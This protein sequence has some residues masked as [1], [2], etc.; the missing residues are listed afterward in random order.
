MFPCGNL[1]ASICSQTVDCITVLLLIWF[2]WGTIQARDDL[3][4]LTWAWIFW[5]L[6]FIPSPFFQSLVV[7]EA[8]SVFL[9]LFLPLLPPPPPPAPPSS[10]S[11]SCCYWSFSLNDGTQWEPQCL[12]GTNM[13]TGTQRGKGTGDSHSGTELNF[14]SFIS[15]LHY[16]AL[17]PRPRLTNHG[18]FENLITM[19][20]STSYFTS[21]CKRVIIYVSQHRLKVIISEFL[22]HYAWSTEHHLKRVV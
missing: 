10:S 7:L 6:F 9:D 22:K 16:H 8:L 18:W 19:W 2:R 1:K 4:K 17:T 12:H 13:L 14:S 5:S 21:T 15:Y 3:P 11:S 20:L